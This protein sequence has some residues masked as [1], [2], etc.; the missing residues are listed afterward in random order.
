[1]ATVLNDRVTIRVRMVAFH[2]PDQDGNVV[3]REVQVPLSQWRQCRHQDDELSLVFHN[4][5]NDVQTI[6]GRSSVSCGDVIEL[7]DKLF[8]VAPM[9][10]DEMSESQYKIY[11]RRRQ[12]EL[13][14][15]RWLP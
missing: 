14:H 11:E 13:R 10:F 9:S 1:M 15:G 7:D 5:Q 2:Q 12:S 8:I 3:I 6:E 4:G